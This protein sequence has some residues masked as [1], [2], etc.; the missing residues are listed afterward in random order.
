MDGFVAVVFVV[1]GVGNDVEDSVDDFVV[2]CEILVVLTE[3][4]V[5]AF[6]VLGVGCGAFVV[7]A[8]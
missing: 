7:T 5:D 3:D 4:E 8:R 2:E 1:E 6:I